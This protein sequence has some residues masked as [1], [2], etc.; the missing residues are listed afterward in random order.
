MFYDDKC[1]WDMLEQVSNCDSSYVGKRPPL[2]SAQGT[3][4]LTTTS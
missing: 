3:P 2:S 1:K 4:N